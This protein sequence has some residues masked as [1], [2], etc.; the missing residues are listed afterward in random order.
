MTLE[1]SNS[2][3]SF[4]SS[5]ICI[6]TTTTGTFAFSSFGEETIESFQFKETSDGNFIEVVK[7]Q[8][9]NSTYTLAVWP[10]REPV[11]R[12]F[13]EIYGITRGEDGKKT[14][15]LLRTIEAEVTPGHYVKESFE[16]P[17]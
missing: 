6:G 4:G 10:P 17:E 2:T 11:D 14:L 1:N 15:Q 9:P 13:K 12:V 5:N 8:K 16:F 7:R 3:T